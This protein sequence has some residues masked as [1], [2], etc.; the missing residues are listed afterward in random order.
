MR[1]AGRAPE[2]LTPTYAVLAFICSCDLRMTGNRLCE[3]L[4]SLSSD[5]WNSKGKGRT[6]T[7]AL[8]CQ[9]CCYI[10]AFCLMAQPRAVQG[11]VAGSVVRWLPPG[12]LAKG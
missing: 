7:W 2:L 12:A 11:S 9:N 1:M 6:V 3:A 4:A 8:A 10:A 5:L